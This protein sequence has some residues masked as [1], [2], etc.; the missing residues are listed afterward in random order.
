MRRV[1]Q[2]DLWTFEFANYDTVNAITPECSLSFFSEA[3][4]QRM[5]QTNA[6]VRG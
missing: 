6:N 1:I 4:V 5:S 2:G 3:D